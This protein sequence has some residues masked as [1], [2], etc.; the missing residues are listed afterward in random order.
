MSGSD[1]TR[2]L[3][4]LIHEPIL[5]LQPFIKDFQTFAS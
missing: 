5:H 3:T 2:Y 1:Y 4:T